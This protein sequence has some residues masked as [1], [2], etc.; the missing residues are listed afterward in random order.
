[1]LKIY[2][3][4]VSETVRTNLSCSII[5]LNT[6]LTPTF[7]V[8]KQA[9]SIFYTNNAGGKNRILINKQNLIILSNS[10]L[11]AKYNGIYSKLWDVYYWS[12]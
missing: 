4:N 6:F 9:I 12:D 1:M 5:D 2:Q 7:N 8:L 3:E 11:P 10:S